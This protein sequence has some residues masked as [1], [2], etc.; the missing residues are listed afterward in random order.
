MV[1]APSHAWDA[2]VRSK[3]LRWY[4]QNHRVLPWRATQ[5]PYAI[6]ISE[7]MLQQTQVATVI[8]FYFRFLERFPRVESL[9]AA[10]EQDVLTHW[11]GLGY[12]RRARQL[13]AAAK[14][15]VERFEGLFPA[16][17]ESLRTLPGI[18]RYTAGAI[19]SFAYGTRA[20][21]L[22]ANTIRLFSRLIELREDPKSSAGQAKLWA[23]AESILPARRTNV[24]IVNQAVMELGSLVCLPQKPKCSAC[25][26][27]S[28]CSAY[29][30]GTQCQ[31][32]MAA[33]E[34]RLDAL[35]HVLVAIHR[36]GKYLLRRNPSGGWWEGLWDFPRVDITNL[37]QTS[38]FDAAAPNRSVNLALVGSAMAR[39]LDLDCQP[40]AYLRTIKHGVTRYRIS[41]YCFEAKLESNYQLPKSPDW[42]WFKLTHKPEIP[43]TSTAE[44]LCQLILA[45]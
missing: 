19:A 37:N 25:P 8:P 15:V 30:S 17:V 33:K 13:H 9:A 16:D 12:Y 24:G 35:V 41:L 20:P 3:L 4:R 5:D 26:V 14:I 23:F 40:T 22:E 39:E 36:R 32:P 6:W 42:R 45:G 10:A 38:E 11:A 18:G 34:K 44:K 21:I 7:I 2:R 27:A 43:L 28:A 29:Q 31:T 1:S